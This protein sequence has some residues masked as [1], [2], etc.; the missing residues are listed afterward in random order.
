MDLMEKDP[1][2]MAEAAKGSEEEWVTSPKTAAGR[3]LRRIVL[4][5]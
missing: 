4:S 3:R 5:A 1:E 2:G